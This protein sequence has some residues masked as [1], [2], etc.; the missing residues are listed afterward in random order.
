MVS[1]VRLFNLQFAFRL[2]SRSSASSGAVEFSFGLAQK[3]KNILTHPRA[4]DIMIYCISMYYPV[5]LCPFSGIFREGALC[6]AL[7]AAPFVRM[8]V[9][10]SGTG[11][12]G[13]NTWMACPSRAGEQELLDNEVGCV[14]LMQHN[15]NVHNVPAAAVQVCFSQIKEVLDL[16]I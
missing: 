11:L 2:T 12:Q 4:L 3:T 16:P 8:I 15:V 9:Q 6:R 14:F 10:G 1:G 13:Y 7:C 5:V